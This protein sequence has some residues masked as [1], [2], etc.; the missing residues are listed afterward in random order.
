MR[1]TFSQGNLRELTP[2]MFACQ[3]GHMPCVLALLEAGAELEENGPGTALHMATANDQEACVRALIKEGAT[4]D[5]FS[6]R[7]HT[8]LM[9]ACKYHYDAIVTALLDANADPRRLGGHAGLGFGLGSALGLLG[10]AAEAQ[11]PFFPRVLPAGRRKALRE[12]RRVPVPWSREGHADFPKPRREQAV[13]LVRAGASLCL[14][15]SNPSAFRNAWNEFMMET[16][17][18]AEIQPMSRVV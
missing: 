17:L 12:Q 10:S 18:P 5:A 7:G 1:G 2:L 3:K 16:Y 9:I 4:V 14:A 8:P 11:L 6:S 15:T 13:A